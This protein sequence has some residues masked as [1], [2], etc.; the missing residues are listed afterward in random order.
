MN[1]DDTPVESVKR[2]FYFAGG[3]LLFWA[4]WNFLTEDDDEEAE[5][6]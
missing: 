5:E 1:I 6:E 2:G 4:L 3:T